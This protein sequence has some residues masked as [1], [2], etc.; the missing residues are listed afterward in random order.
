MG[1]SKRPGFQCRSLDDWALPSRSP[2]ILGVNDAAD[3]F[4]FNHCLGDTPGIL[5]CNDSADPGLCLAAQI[6]EESNVA[7]AEV[8]ESVTLEQLSQIVSA[9]AAKNALDQVN[10]AMKA[11]H[12][13]TPARKAAFLAQISEESA[14]LTKLSEG[15]SDNYFNNAYGPTTNAGKNVGNTETGDGAR[16]KGR[17]MIQL[18]GREN[19]TRACLYFKLEVTEDKTKKKPWFR[20]VDP[21]D[22]ETASDPDWSAKIAA[23]YW[24]VLR[25]VNP[26]ADQLEESA[27][28]NKTFQAVT[29]KINGGLNGLDARIEYYKKAKKALGINWGTLHWTPPKP[30]PKKSNKAKPPAKAKHAKSKGKPKAKAKPKPIGNT[31]MS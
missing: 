31:P 28:E 22:P 27:D 15:G 16:F 4:G 30:K 12:I 6:D 10:A 1:D 5:G 7:Q 19:Y 3:P 20:H 2:G 8:D 14:G 9:D 24:D 23:W 18:T 13:N 17:G 26:V 25:N 11:G 29:K 21:K